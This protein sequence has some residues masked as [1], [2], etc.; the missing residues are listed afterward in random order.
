MKVTDLSLR[1]KILQTVVLRV[2]KDNY[3]AEPG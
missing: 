3:G 2:N 1:E